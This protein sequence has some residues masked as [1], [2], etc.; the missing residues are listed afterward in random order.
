M[1]D[2]TNTYI[3]LKDVRDTYY[4]CRDFELQHLWQRSIF[5]SAFLVLCFTGYGAILKTILC[6]EY[7]NSIFFHEIASGLAIIGIVFSLIWIMM[8]KGSKAWYEVY[9]EAITEIEQ[10]SELKIP[11]EMIMGNFTEINDIDS[12]ILTSKAGKY[13][14][15]KLNIVIGRVLFFIWSIIFLI[16]FIFVI[17]LVPCQNRCIH[18][19]ILIFMSIILTII[20]L[21]ASLNTWARSSVLSSRK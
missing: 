6:S 7:T 14:P 20:V 3:T 5:L 18:I 4:H 2:N 17:T 12:N 9:E 8:S 11:E 10:N 19:C 1:A 16:H 21:T 15:S 13:S